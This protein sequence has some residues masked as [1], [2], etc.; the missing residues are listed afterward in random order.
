M[1]ELENYTGEFSPQIRLEDF[2]KEV[3]VDLVKMYTKLYM[4]L[5]GFWYLTVKERH[6]NEEALT[7]DIKTWEK[8]SGYEMSKIAKQLNIKGD[9]VIAFMKALQFSPW[10]L[11]LEY[12]MEIINSRKA[13]LTVTHCS[14]LLALEKEGEGRENEICNMVYPGLLKGLASFFNPNIEVRC[15]KSPPRQSENDICCKW[16][17]SL[18]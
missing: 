7:C 9:D 14:T 5:D 17:F 16:E 10:Y 6:G 15:L 13:A 1:K 12:Q 18:A 3:L 11:H 4:A 8:Q 2:S